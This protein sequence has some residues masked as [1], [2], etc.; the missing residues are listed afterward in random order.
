MMEGRDRGKEEK[1]E[2]REKQ[3]LPLQKKKERERVDREKARDKF[4]LGGGA[5]IV[6]G[7]TCLLRWSEY[8]GDGEG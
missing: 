5:R 2:G 6:V 1:G 3:C 7:G 8:P 4:A